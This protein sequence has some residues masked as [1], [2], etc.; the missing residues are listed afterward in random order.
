MSDPFD[1]IFSLAKEHGLILNNLIQLDSGVFR[2]NWRRAVGTP[3][4][5]VDDRDPRAALVNALTVAVNTLLAP[6]VELGG[7]FD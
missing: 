6:A 7:L 5:F 4:A 2:A 3:A 1:D